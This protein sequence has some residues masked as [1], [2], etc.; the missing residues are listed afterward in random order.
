MTI[1]PLQHFGLGDVI[2]TQ[3]LVRNIANGNPIVWGTL[4][5]FVDGLNCAY[6]DI[7]FVDW[8][9]LGIDY[10]CKQH[11]EIDHHTLG[12]CTL[13]PIRWADSIMKVPYTQCMRSKYDMYGLDWQ[14]WRDE[15]MWVKNKWNSRQLLMMKGYPKT[16]IN[17]T[18]GSDSKMKVKIEVDGCKMETKTG[19]SLFDWQE[20]IQNATH[21]HT[22]ST[23]IIY[24]L[25]MLDLK[26][27]EINLYNRPIK[28]QGFDNID[29]ILKRHKYIFH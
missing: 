17:D 18:Y 5:H 8:R 26:A 15:A 28:G 6:P 19:Y 11:K 13:L 12:K 21:I 20:V 27:K 22:V 7:K 23:S 9:T 14:T 4:P 1:L 3:T 25:E 29:Y 24:L 16:L 2:F 10:D